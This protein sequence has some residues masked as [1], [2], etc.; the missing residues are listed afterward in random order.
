MC[1]ADMIPIGF[2][3]R[4]GSQNE[5]LQKW[6]C[7]AFPARILFRM[8]SHPYQ[9][10]VVGDLGVG[11]SSTTIQYVHNHFLEEIDPTLED[12]YRKSTIID[13]IEAELV[14]WDTT[15]PEAY[16]ESRH[17]H[18]Y[19]SE[20]F[21][22]MYSITSSSSL[23]NIVSFKERICDM[24][25]GQPPMVLVGNKLDLHTEREL[26]HWPGYDLARSWGIPFFEISASIRINVEESFSE[27]VRMIRMEREKAAQ[28]AARR[29]SG[30]MIH[31]T[32]S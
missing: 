13:D 27:L 20:G 16:T 12:S 18:I 22:L 5:R 19:M 14:I 7:S 30:A 1:S 31:C 8:N 32:I 9:V 21:L 28:L 6:G 10:A 29:A 24:L 26:P 25:Q 3:F 4:I 15:S 11:K 2:R 23:V 17:Q